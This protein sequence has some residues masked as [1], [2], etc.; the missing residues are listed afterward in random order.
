MTKKIVA[1]LALSLVSASAFASQAH[2]IISGGGD[3]GRIL[4]AGGMCGSFYT[5]DEYNMFWNPAFINGQKNYLVIEN[6]AGSG[7]S[8][9]FV[10]DVANFNLGVFLNRPVAQ[11]SPAAPFGAMGVVNQ[12][13]D[14][15]LGGEM[16]V[17]WG[18]GLTHAFNTSSG[19]YTNLKAGVIV[20]DFEPFVSYA[21]KNTDGAATET[22]ATDMTVG[23]R[24][25]F[26][27]WRP[28]AAYRALKVNSVSE[29]FK[30]YGLGV[31]RMAKMGDVKLDYSLS[32]W[33]S[34]G[35]AGVV[36]KSSVIPVEISASADAASWLAVHAGF[37][38]DLMVRNQAVTTTTTLGGTFKM[39][40]AD[41]DMVVGNNTAGKFGVDENLFA[42]AGLTYRW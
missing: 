6:G 39:G 28:Y 13:V 27:E 16:G 35:V 34:T 40:K 15:V 42:N 5:D 29:S 26:G 23:T 4:C 33:K 7:T 12:T 36:S 2:N 22:K 30:A 14:L 41:L 19:K 11:T 24:Y 8:A 38:H 32:Y 20:S 17:K 31:G 18:V 1:V 21:I 25:H 3:G 10:T 9:G 37:K